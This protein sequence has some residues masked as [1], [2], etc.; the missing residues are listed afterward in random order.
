MSGVSKFKIVHEGEFEKEV[1]EEEFE[2]KEYSIEVS[3]ES[4][5]RVSLGGSGFGMSGQIPKTFD[6][7]AK[8]ESVE[9]NVFR[10]KDEI[11]KMKNDINY[12]SRFEVVLNGPGESDYELAVNDAGFNDIRSYSNRT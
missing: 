12:R 9:E 3:T 7:V 4:S 6:L 5:I 2:Y 11:E 8:D 10:Q 1:G